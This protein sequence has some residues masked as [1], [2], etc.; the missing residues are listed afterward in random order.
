VQHTYSHSFHT[1]RGL[2]IHVPTQYG[3]QVGKNIIRQVVNRWKPPSHFFHFRHG[4]HVAACQHHIAAHYFAHLDIQS[5]FLTL[6]SS[7]VHR[8]MRRLKFSQAQA[9]EI[10]RLSTVEV[11]RQPRKY[12]LPFGFTQSMI[13]ASATLDLSQLGRHLRSA[14]DH[15]VRVSVYVDDIIIS[16]FKATDVTE[17][18]ALTTSAAALSGYRLNDRKASITDETTEA[19]NIRLT[20][21]QLNVTPARMAEFEEAVRR[22]DELSGDAVIRYV[23][24]VNEGQAHTLRV[25]NVRP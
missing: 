4:G 23:A 17:F 21:G 10:V 6:T 25:G 7:K 3:R 2:L 13:L 11:S 15:N 8:A 16:G 1:S 12:A 24:S 20:A 5:F 22:G 14:E 18:I 9:L 19:F